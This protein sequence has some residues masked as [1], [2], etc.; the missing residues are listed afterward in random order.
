MAGLVSVIIPTHNREKTIERAVDSVLNQT[1][2]NIEII[3]VDDCSTDSTL[4]VLKSRYG[5]FAN[6]TIFQLERNSGACVARNKGIDLSRGEYIAFLDSDDA[7]LEEKIEKQI[8]ALEKSGN[9]L[10]ATSYWRI[11]ASGKKKTIHVKTDGGDSLY[12]ELLFCNFIT[13]GTL[14]GEAKI[15]KTERFDES[16]PRYQDWD[17]VLRLASNYEFD[18]LDEETLLQEYQ[19]ISITSST[20]HQKTYNAMKVIYEKH[21]DSFEK[22]IRARVQ[23]TWLMGLQS[24]YTESKRYDY[25]WCGVIGHGFNLRRFILWMYYLLGLYHVADLLT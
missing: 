8:S 6:V 4:E 17:L 2:K 13:T 11:D 10:C 1:Y 16:L 20:S 9:K 19:P 5:G 22:D 3:I 24:M 23:Y 14:V 21:K 18:L 7:F 12:N 15:F 25:L